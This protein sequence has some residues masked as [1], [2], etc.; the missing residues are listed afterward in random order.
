[1]R[2][3]CAKMLLWGC[4][5]P[6]SLARFCLGSLPSRTT[7]SCPIS[8]TWSLDL[9]CLV[10]R[11]L[12]TALGFFST[13]PSAQPPGSLLQV[14]SR[15]SWSPHSR[16]CLFWDDVSELRIRQV[17]T[18]RREESREERQFLSQDFITAEGEAL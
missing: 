18:P 5:S 8:L 4:S 12:R 10:S 2:S 9:G 11:W 7:G 3:P 16:H 1:M 17:R 13:G 15:I 14:Q 6:S